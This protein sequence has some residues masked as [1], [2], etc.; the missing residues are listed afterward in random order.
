MSPEATATLGPVLVVGAAGRHGSTGRVVLEEL[1]A[2][3]IAVR[4]L[5]RQDDERVASLREQGVDVVVGDLRDRAGMLRALDGCTSAYFTYPVGEGV[6]EAAAAF[7]SAA[8]ER[9]LQRIVSMSMGPSH[10]QSPSPLGRAQWLAEEVIQWSGVSCK[11]LRIA[12]LFFEN[13]LVLHGD[14]IR[15]QAQFS[16]CFGDARVPW[17]AGE[18]AARIAVAAFLRPERFPSA[19]AYFPGVEHRSHPEIADALTRAVGRAVGYRAIDA[20][21]WA[22][23]LRARAIGRSSVINDAMATHISTLGAVLAAGRAPMLPPDPDAIADLIGRRP[24]SLDS[25][26]AQNARSFAGAA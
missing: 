6:T 11:I 25:F 20:S 10:A 17:I 26:L 16:N 15:E 12:A 4:A 2:A 13:L 7:A 22:K 19:V 24:R 5:A 14:D 23:D 21:T 1:R 3:G 18:D 9:G 8:R